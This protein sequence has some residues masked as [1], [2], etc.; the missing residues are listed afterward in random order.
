LTQR[1][2]REVFGGIE[3]KPRIKVASGESAVFLGGS[4]IEAAIVVGR[5]F[6]LVE[7]A[8]ADRVRAYLPQ[9]RRVG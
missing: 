6:V 8:S 4:D 1:T 5:T 9:L 2:L 3:G 7:G